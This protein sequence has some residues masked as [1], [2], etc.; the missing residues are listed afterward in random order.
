MESKQ[1]V[2]DCTSIENWIREKTQKDHIHSREQYHMYE[3]GYKKADVSTCSSIV[4]HIYL[5]LKILVFVVI[6]LVLLAMFGLIFY[7]VLIGNAL[8]SALI[9]SRGIKGLIDNGFVASVQVTISSISQWLG[10][11]YLSYL[12]YPFI[13][14]FRFLSNLNINFSAVNVTCEGSK[15]PLEL[16]INCLI[17]GY[18]VKVIESGYLIFNSTSFSRTNKILGV[19]VFSNNIYKKILSQIFV[20]GGSI[21][22]CLFANGNP[23]QMI[24]RYLVGFLFLKEFA[25][26]NYFLH[27]DSAP[28]NTIAHVQNIDLFYSV[29]A[30]VVAWSVL[31]PVI[32]MLASVLVPYDGY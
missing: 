28:C 17:V 21:L 20:L 8:F 13:Y 9:I 7:L 3:E 22:A 31:T 30:S 16:F 2:H 6:S 11:S 12:M 19:S 4:S 25:A 24:L 26:K 23:L 18:I 27:I 10:L 29:A 14:T 15:A 32:Y 1:N 5:Y